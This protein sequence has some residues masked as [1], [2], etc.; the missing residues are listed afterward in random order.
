MT[1][2][3]R[4]FTVL[5]AVAV[6]VFLS[7]AMQ[8]R[9][10]TALGCLI[11]WATCSCAPGTWYGACDTTTNTRCKVVATEPCDKTVNPD[12]TVTC[13]FGSVTSEVVPCK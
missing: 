11:D 13:S 3:H 9:A 8:S 4:S 5:A 7:G 2:K 1:P 10:T 12:G 6:A